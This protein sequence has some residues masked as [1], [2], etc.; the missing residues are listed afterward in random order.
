VLQ[1]AVD[2]PRLRV[3]EAS[4]AISLHTKVGYQRS[5]VH[6]DLPDPAFRTWRNA[7][8]PLLGSLDKL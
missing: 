8:W 1:D 3:W 6:C 4:F 7:E 2:Q 5:R